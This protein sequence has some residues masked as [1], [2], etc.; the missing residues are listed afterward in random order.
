MPIQFRHVFLNLSGYFE[1][2]QTLALIPPREWIATE[3]SEHDRYHKKGYRKG[4]PI[5]GV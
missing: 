5:V 3:T 4:L 2:P 1:A